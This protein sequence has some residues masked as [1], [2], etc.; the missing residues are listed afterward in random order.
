MVK[1]CMDSNF[2]SWYVFYLKCDK[3]WENSSYQVYIEFCYSYV[4]V[5]LFFNKVKIWSILCSNFGVE[6]S[7]L[8]QDNSYCWKVAT[9]K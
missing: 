3:G 6:K 4:L 5:F 7:I 9:K 1:G 2:F 8:P